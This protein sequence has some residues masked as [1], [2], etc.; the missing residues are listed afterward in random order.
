PLS[1]AFPRLFSLSNQKNSFVKDLGEYIGVSW[2][3]TFSWRRELFRWEEDLVVQLRELLE[4]VNFSLVDDSWI[5]RPDPDG[6][7]TV[8]SSYKLLAEELRVEEDLEEEIVKV[9]DHI[10]D[11]P[12][13]SKVI[14]FSWQLLYDRIPTRRNLEARG[15]LGSEL[16][17]EC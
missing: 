9:F 1:V 8:N 3:W 13:P 15:L 4:P 5:W 7:F 17:W 14:A 6:V 2:R 10:W 16:P 11:S 12:A